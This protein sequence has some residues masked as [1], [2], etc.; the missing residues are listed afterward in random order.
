MA[1]RRVTLPEL[2]W[3]FLKLGCISFGGPVAHLGYFQTEFVQRRR[4]LSDADYADLVALC[5]FL[6]GPASSQVGY[7]IGLR[8]GGFVGG[9]LAWVGFTLPSAVLMIG[10]ALGVVALGDVSRA[11]W[12]VGLKLAAVAVVVQAIWG[13]AVKLCPD[14]P[15][16][17]LAVGAAALLVFTTGALWQVVAI[18]LGGVVGWILFRQEAGNAPRAVSAEGRGILLPGWGWL[19]VFAVGLFGL[20]ALVKAGVGGEIL[21]VFDGFYRAGS[22]VF[23]GGHVVLPLLDAFTVGRDWIEVEVFLAGYGAAQALPGPLFAFSSFLGASISTGPGGVVGG[24]WALLA[25][26]VPSWLLILGAMPYWE[27]L[28][29]VPAAQAALK[30]T[31]AAV[32]GLL[33]AA[34]IDPIWPAAMTSPLRIVVAAA[35]LAALKFTKLPPWALV[36]ACGGLGAVLF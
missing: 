4:W 22:L 33:L 2:F 21:T 6:P 30:G 32:V 28:R 18:L 7:A 23:G 27:K 34:L 26:Y 1:D 25:I 17:A 14:V 19:L 36:L 5:Q 11:G 20:P 35:A 9:L 10:F 13:M 3:C 16:A 12:V 31:N 8:E 15:R 29:Q 24:V